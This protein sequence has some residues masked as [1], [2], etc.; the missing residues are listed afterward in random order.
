MCFLCN[1]RFKSSLELM[2]CVIDISTLNK[3]YLIFDFT[4]S[5][6]LSHETSLTLPL[7]TQQENKTVVYLCGG[8]SI[9]PLFLYDFSIRFCNCSNSF[10][11]FY[12]ESTQ[13]RSDLYL[14]SLHRILT[15]KNAQLIVANYCIPHAPY[16]AFNFRKQIIPACGNLQGADKY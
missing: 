14:I 11:Q 5:G 16:P 13:L 12:Y 8:V 4:K 10:S 2:L 6:G 7:F 1:S 9:L 15:I 3:T